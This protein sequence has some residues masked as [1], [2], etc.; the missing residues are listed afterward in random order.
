[1]TNWIILSF[2]KNFCN[3]SNKIINYCLQKICR[4]QKYNICAGHNLMTEV[5][6]FDCIS[7]CLIHTIY[8]KD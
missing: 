1:M 2:I 6:E 7:R 8:F 4:I 5:D 3:G